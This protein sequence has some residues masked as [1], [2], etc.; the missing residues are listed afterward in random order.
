MNAKTFF[1]Q[2][3]L[4]GYTSVGYRGEHVEKLW[5]P[6][7]D[8][9]ILVE[10]ITEWDDTAK[11]VKRNDLADRIADYFRGKPIEFRDLVVLPDVTDF[12]KVVYKKL[13]SIK[14]GKTITYGAL[15]ELC[16]RPG[17][18]RAVGSI[19]AKN[20]IPLI[21]PCHRVIKS[22]GGLGGFSAPGGIGMKEKMLQLE[23][24]IDNE[25]S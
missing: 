6:E 14:R 3:T 21:I 19:M 20:Q 2:K 12:S 4:F 16:G 15:A 8:R 11:Q 22:D 17:S 13:R 9:Q 5:L 10:R 1:I 24:K 23:R 25:T 7:H 18:A